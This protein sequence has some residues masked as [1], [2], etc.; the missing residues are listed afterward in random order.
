[1]AERK[2]LARRSPIDIE[3]ENRSDRLKL[4]LALTW[5]ALAENVLATL[6]S[7]ADTIMVSNLGEVAVAAVGLVTQPR[8]IVMSSFMALGIGTT[9]LVARA[10]GKGDREEARNAMCQSL[11]LALAIVVIVTAVMLVFS[12]PLIRM[13]AGSKNEEQ[14]IVYAVQ[15]FRVQIYGFPT[16]GLTFIFTAALR[17]SRIREPRS[18]QIPRP[19]S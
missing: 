17:G 10:K 5:P 18:T 3:T 19:I 1:M 14:A 7:M 8:F 15:Y 9:A 13:I 6:V 16:L 12:E 2:V 4:I 11:L